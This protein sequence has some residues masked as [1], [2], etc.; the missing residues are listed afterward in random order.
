MSEELIPDRL[1]IVN[2]D[3]SGSICAQFNPEEVKEQLEVAYARLAILGMSHQPM[4]Y[5]Y[6]GNL[7]LS[8][9]LGFDELSARGID[10]GGELAT[11]VVEGSIG[12][13]RPELARRFIHSLCYSSK[14]T[15]DIQSGDPPDVLVVWPELYSVECKLT[16][17]AGSMKRFR[18]K[19]MPTHF[20]LSLEF[21]EISDI[22]KYSDE[23]LTLGTA[24][25]SR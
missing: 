14:Q 18:K 10:L 22:R 5:Q 25:S 20:V 1:H 23:V 19:G 11:K 21:E 16:K 4:Q 12:G 15:Q 24:R 6:T 17:L 2:L 9:D 8:F 3:T 7:K 13:G